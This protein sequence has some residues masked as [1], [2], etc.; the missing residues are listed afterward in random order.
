LIEHV[1]AYQGVKKVGT[2]IE[3][4]NK[5]VRLLASKM[6]VDKFN[7]KYSNLNTQQKRI[8]REYINNV[9][10]SVKLKKY[11]LSETTKLQNT[12]KSL[13]S[14]VPS[15][16]VRIKVNEVVNLLKELNKKHVVQDKDV[17][18]MLRYYELVNELKKIGDK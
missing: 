11:V 16:V 7:N 8:L 9:T 3:E 6:V 5:D 17:L 18:T 10:N 4:Q 12:L 14:H 1:Q 2:L 15:K 13:K